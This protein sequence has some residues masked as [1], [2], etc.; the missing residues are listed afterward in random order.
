MQKIH[1]SPSARQ[2]HSQNGRVLMEINQ[3]MMYAPNPVGGRIIKLLSQGLTT[4]EVVETVKRECDV[5]QETVHRDLEVFVERL[6]S[7]DI[8]S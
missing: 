3:G 8:V 7:Y 2:E 5:P 1:I 4:S 6:N